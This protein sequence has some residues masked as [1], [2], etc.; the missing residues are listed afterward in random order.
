MMP[1]VLL[2]NTLKMMYEKWPVSDQARWWAESAVM[3][4]PRALMKFIE[5]QHLVVSMLATQVAI[6]NSSN[7]RRGSC[8]Q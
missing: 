5:A 2:V 6:A 3:D 4:Q 8:N 7:R 1:I